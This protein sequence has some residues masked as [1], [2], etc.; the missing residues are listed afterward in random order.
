MPRQIEIT[1]VTL[2]AAC[3]VVPSLATAEDGVLVPNV[4]AP[5]ASFTKS[6]GAKDTFVARGED[7]AR[8]V[9]FEAVLIT[10]GLGAKIALEAPA[11][12]GDQPARLALLEGGFYLVVGSKGIE[13]EL[14]DSVLRAV[15]A[16][17]M[18]AKLGDT[19]IVQVKPED[20]QGRVELVPPPLPEPAALDDGAAVDED[21]AAPVTTPVPTPVVLPA[22]KRHTLKNGKHHKAERRASD[23][24]LKTIGRLVP[25]PGGEPQP[26][27]IAQLTP[28]DIEDPRDFVVTATGSDAALSDL[29]IEDIEVDVGCVEIC[30][31]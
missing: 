27:H 2:L 29:E 1:A 25:E 4:E 11:G 22:N 28:R 17:V 16:E 26:K 19:W 31:D 10:A 21:E 20:E 15:N 6:K 8:M 3:L 9:A 7:R 5:K 23:F 30:V 18:L 14:G 13:L 12:E 24:L